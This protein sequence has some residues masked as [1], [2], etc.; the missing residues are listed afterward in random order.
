MNSL[1]NIRPRPGPAGG[2]IPFP[3]GN[4]LEVRYLTSMQPASNNGCRVSTLSDNHKPIQLAQEDGEA[5]KSEKPEENLFIS[6]L[7]LND[8]DWAEFLSQIDSSWHQQELS[9]PVQESVPVTQPTFQLPGKLEI[10]VGPGLMTGVS[11]QPWVGAKPAVVMSTPCSVF[12][13]QTVG[14]SQ[15]TVSRSVGSPSTAFAEECFNRLSLS[16]KPDPFPPP[17]QTAYPCPPIQPNLDQLLC[18]PRAAG[19]TGGKRSY[20]IDEDTELGK[21]CS[22][23]F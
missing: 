18:R 4:Q 7:V 9:L 8:A 12:S 10:P 6:D 14:S 20:P 22:S 13:P 5:Q 3:T 23:Y 1:L 2:S 19:R 17:A 21:V 11:V 15:L 16:A